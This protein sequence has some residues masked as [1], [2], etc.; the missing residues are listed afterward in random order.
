MKNIYKT[1]GFV[2]AL[3]LAFFVS[4]CEDVEP[5]IEEIVY[6]RAFTPLELDVKVRNQITAEVK[7]K[8][9]EGIKQYD[10]EISNDSLE[11]GSIVHT[12][13]VLANELPVSILLESE[14]Q[15]SVRIKAISELQGQDDSKWTALPF[16]TDA[17]NIFNAITDADKGKTETDTWVKLSWPANSAVTHLVIN[18]GDNE[19]QRDL[20]TDE[21]EAGEVTL[22]GLPF[23][24]EYTVKLFNGTNPKQRGNVTFTTLPEGET[25]TPADNLNDKIANANDGDVF[26]LEGGV[27]EAYMGQITIDKS[28]KLQGLS[29]EDKPVLNVQFVLNDGAQ[30]AKF[31]NLEMNGSYTDETAAAVILDHA[32]QFNSGATALGDVIIDGCRIYNYNKS[33]ISGAS[34]EFSVNSITVNNC[35]VS[36]IFGNGGDFIDFRK[37]FPA[38]ISVSNTTFINCATVSNRD[39]F[40]LDGASKGNLFD[41]G[42][43]T[44]EIIVTANTFYNVQNNASGGKRFFY[45]RWQNSD[46]VISVERNLF[47]DATSNYSSSGDTNMPSFSKNNYFN[48]PGFLDTSK[49]VYDGSGTHTEEDPGFADAANNDLSISNQILIDNQVGDPRWR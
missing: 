23:D 27:Y 4:A 34:G 33:F 12:Q 9:T 49:S 29:S 24:T 35:F 36:D 26:L 25:L 38:F 14:E 43:H 16:K 17:E 40:R 31:I 48:A 19:T 3:I 6:E 11:F 8:T 10:L 7:W 32:F 21:I 1:Y 47:V 39:F 41:D 2:F 37:S 22:E 18:P 28:I 20:T 44:P 13:T 30:S 15:Y 45:V 42:A 5:L 46:E